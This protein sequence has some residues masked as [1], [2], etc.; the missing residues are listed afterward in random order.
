MAVPLTAST[1][2]QCS[3]GSSPV[4]LSD[5]ADRQ[6]SCKGNGY[7]GYDRYGATG[8]HRHLWHV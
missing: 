4:P 1:P 6:A 7:G 3:F 8:E 2:L 5:L